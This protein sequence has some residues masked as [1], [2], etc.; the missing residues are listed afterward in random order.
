MPITIAT[1]IVPTPRLRLPTGKPKPIASN[2]RAIS[3]ATPSPAKMPT[4]DAITPTSNASAITLVS[5]W[6]REAPNVRNSPSSLMRWPT[7]IQKVLKMMNA[8]A[9]VETTPIAIRM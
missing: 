4:T 1:M 5:S 8:P 2:S 3:F 7:V 9:S 6:R